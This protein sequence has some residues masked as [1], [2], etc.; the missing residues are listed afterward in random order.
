MLIARFAIHSLRP[1]GRIRSFDV[2]VAF[3]AIA[4]PELQRITE[5]TALEVPAIGTVLWQC[6]SKTFIKLELL[7]RH[8]KCLRAFMFLGLLAIFL[9]RS[10]EDNIVQPV[11]LIPFLRGHVGFFLEILPSIPF[12]ER[13]FFGERKVFLRIGFVVRKRTHSDGEKLPV[14]TIIAHLRNDAC[15]ELVEGLFV[16]LLV[17]DAVLFAFQANTT[18][19]VFHANGIQAV[20][21]MR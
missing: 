17:E 18:K 7:F 9:P 6:N 3:C 12:C 10:T 4:M 1:I 15:P 20:L 13:L 19:T 11:C 8:L 2:F 14:F 5:F 21:Y 16:V